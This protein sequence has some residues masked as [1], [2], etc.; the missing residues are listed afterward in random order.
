MP[1]LAQRHFSQQGFILYDCDDKVA[2]V[3]EQAGFT[4]GSRVGVA[5]RRATARRA[6]LDAATASRT[7]DSEEDGRPGLVGLAFGKCR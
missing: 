5:D 4:A 1:P 2:A 3:L 6:A 7:M